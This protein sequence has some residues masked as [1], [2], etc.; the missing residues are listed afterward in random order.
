VAIHR[1]LIAKVWVWS[2]ANTCKILSGHRG[3]DTCVFHASIILPL[4][5]IYRNIAV[6]KIT[7]GR[8]LGILKQGNVLPKIG[9]KKFWHILVA[10]PNILSKFLCNVTFW[11]LI[12]NFSSKTAKL[13]CCWIRKTTSHRSTFQSFTVCQLPLRVG[14]IRVTPFEFLRNSEFI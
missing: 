11:M 8:S 6:I 2:Q 14:I 5:P 7:N 10:L 1:P 12:I 3:T 13:F 4:Q 9:Q